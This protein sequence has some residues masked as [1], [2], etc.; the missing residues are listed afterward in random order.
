MFLKVAGF[1]CRTAFI[2]YVFA[3][4]VLAGM[5]ERFKTLEFIVATAS[6]ATEFTN[7]GLSLLRQNKGKV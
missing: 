7:G 6:S 2:L 3:F 4:I 5:L 1:Q